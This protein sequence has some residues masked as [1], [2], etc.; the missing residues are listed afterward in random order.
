MAQ[1]LAL[2]PVRPERYA[3]QPDMIIA[4]QA[5]ESG[6]LAIEIQRQVGAPTRGRGDLAP[7]V[8]DVAPSTSLRIVGSGC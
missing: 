8:G 6:D 7:G 3:V 5:A 2:Q 4:A 1:L